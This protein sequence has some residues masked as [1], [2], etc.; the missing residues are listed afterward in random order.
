MQ[1]TPEEIKRLTDAGL[2]FSVDDQWRFPVRTI[3]PFEE[4]MET[5]PGY[6]C[7]QTVEETYAIAQ[8]MADNHPELAAWIDVG[9]SWE[10]TAGLGGYDT[11][12]LVLT[13]DLVSGEKPKFFATFSASAISC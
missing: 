9:D 6:P 13:N 12:V 8:E 5:I 7:Y 10:K 11:M 3:S 1:V 4:T 2:Q